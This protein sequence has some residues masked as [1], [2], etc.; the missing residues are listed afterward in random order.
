MKTVFICKSM[1]LRIEGV[2]HRSYRVN[3]RINLK[4][5]G[6]WLTLIVEEVREEGG[7]RQVWLKVGEPLRKQVP[8][9]PVAP[10]RPSPFS[11]QWIEEFVEAIEGKR[12]SVSF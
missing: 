1:N 8:A 12:G 9:T 6:R 11:E 10:P 2:D 4:H 5:Q 7:V 3:E